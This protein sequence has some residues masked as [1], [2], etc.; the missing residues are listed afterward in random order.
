MTKTEILE[1]I[2]RLESELEKVK[3][4][5][6]P[7][8]K[9]TTRYEPRYG[10]HNGE[11]GEY[12]KETVE[13]WQLSD[14]EKG[15]E[16]EKKNEEIRKLQKE[17]NRLQ[18]E[19]K[20]T[21]EYDVVNTKDK[22]L[23]EKEKELE[24]TKIKENRDEENKDLNDLIAIFKRIGM[25][26]LAEDLMN[27]PLA[28]KKMNSSYVQDEIQIQDQ[29]LRKTLNR[30]TTRREYR[31]IKSRVKNL[32]KKATELAKKYKDLLYLAQNANS[33]MDEIRE[34]G[35]E[36][37]PE[38]LKN[39]FV[40]GKG[41]Y[42]LG[43][44]YTA[45]YF[46]PTSEY[47]RDRKKEPFGVVS[48]E[49]TRDMLDARLETIDEDYKDLDKLIQIL[50]IAGT[51]DSTLE[52]LAHDLYNMRFVNQKNNSLYIENHIKYEAEKRAY[53]NQKTSVSEKELKEIKKHMKF[54]I[55]KATKAAKRYK[56]L[57]RLY[58][59]AGEILADIKA[60]RIYMD[61]ISLNKYFTERFT[62]GYTGSYNQNLG[63]TYTEFAR[64]YDS[65]YAKDS[66]NHRI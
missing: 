8:E 9:R 21:P 3:A 61:H 66:R 59:H 54:I 36:Y 44:I 32:T 17:I 23:L 25:R 63:Y 20:K 7:N 60:K 37:D 16:K 45:F 55:K 34:K 48:K 42:N 4:R 22:R 49:E 62:P 53:L 58:L 14:Y 27:M 52:N 24:A 30:A 18:E 56:D 5:E 26:D 46:D 31:E 43:N 28:N 57:Y 33:I 11:F 19:Y 35:I 10:Y 51:Y 2:L 15:I 47:A 29:E 41:Y 64:D 50:N 39:Y 38:K 13:T 65:E 1:E 12:M 40:Y 6:I